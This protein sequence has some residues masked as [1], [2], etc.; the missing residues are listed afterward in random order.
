MGYTS[1]VKCI[2]PKKNILFQCSLCHFFIKKYIKF[3]WE[4]RKKVKSYESY[5]IEQ[6]AN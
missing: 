3:Q 1:E 6:L 4:K 2:F 5:F